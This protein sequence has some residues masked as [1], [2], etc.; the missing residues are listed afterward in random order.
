MD[1]AQA[2]VDDLDT[3]G[4][5]VGI[6]SQLV[7]HAAPGR[8]RVMQGEDLQSRVALEHGTHCFERSRRVAL[9]GQDGAVVL[10]MEVVCQQEI[11][12]AG[13]VANYG[14][15]ERIVGQVRLRRLLLARLLFARDDAGRGAVDS[16]PAF[17]H[18][19]ER[20]EIDSNEPRPLLNRHQYKSHD[21]CR[22]HAQP[23]AGVDLNSPD[24]RPRSER[25]QEYPED[26]KPRRGNPLPAADLIVEVLDSP[27]HPPARG[28]GFDGVLEGRIRQRVAG[29]R[30]E[31]ELAAALGA[32]LVWP[33]LILAV[34][35]AADAFHAAP[36]GRL[37][38]PSMKM[39]S[40][41]SSMASAQSRSPTRRR[42][43]S[44]GSLCPCRRRAM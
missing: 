20:R 4:E 15:V 19:I 1:G 17:P 42:R 26:N 11:D 6:A 5:P 18:A 32:T 43:V 16:A 21:G 38:R 22:H 25:S 10:K 9:D 31:G 35:L 36:P 41:A 37:P 3:A 24:H 7:R 34:M 2:N 30:L 29:A 39:R 44:F 27:A 23:P 40:Q 28:H 13:P 12:R 14:T 8:R 33:L